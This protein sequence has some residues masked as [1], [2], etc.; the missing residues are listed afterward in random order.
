MRSS[1]ASRLSRAVP[2]KKLSANNLILKHMPVESRPV[3]LTRSER[4]WTYGSH[5]ETQKRLGGRTIT[6]S[7][8]QPGNIWERRDSSNRS[9]PTPSGG[10]TT[11]L[12][13]SQLFWSS[14]PSKSP[15][16]APTCPIGRILGLLNH[17]LRCRANQQ[18]LRH[19]RAP[20][21]G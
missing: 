1:Q 7:T 12:Q 18:A 21:K 15:Q 6:A 20:V 4:I 8:R 10:G 13:T 5:Q 14:D 17:R 11:Y 9:S 19:H 3:S 16:F 2:R